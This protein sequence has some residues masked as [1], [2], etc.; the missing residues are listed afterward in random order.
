MGLAAPA[1]LFAQ[2]IGRDESHVAVPKAVSPAA[3]G[4]AGGAAPTRAQVAKVREEVKKELKEEKVARA[5]AVLPQPKRAAEAKLGGGSAPAAE[6]FL[7]G[8]PMQSATS[9]V[10][11]AKLV[12]E[13]KRAPKQLPKPKAKRPPISISQAMQ[14][15][16]STT[17][18]AELA[19]SSAPV[20]A[21][22]K[23]DVLEMSRAARA[24]VGAPSSSASVG[25]GV[26]GGSA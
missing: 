15:A 25:G 8:P 17:S 1:P 24:A 6:A 2:D 4:S 7:A 21:A 5:K 20:R 11:G 14:S 3:E 13:V 19:A 16:T 26:G 18:G 23:V 22:P 9:S 10:E 12:A